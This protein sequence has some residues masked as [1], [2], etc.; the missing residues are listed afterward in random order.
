MLTLPIKGLWFHKIKTG[1]KLEEY[2]EIKPYYT[3]R[4]NTV[5]GDKPEEPKWIRLR[6]GYSA[7]SPQMYIK[8]ILSKGHGKQEWGAVRGKK[9]YVLRILDKSMEKPEEIK[10]EKVDKGC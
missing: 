7:E 9:Y 10:H 8:C 5:F 4:F 6:Q 3:S 2:R 1:I